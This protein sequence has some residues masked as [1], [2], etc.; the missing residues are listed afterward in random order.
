MVKNVLRRMRFEYVLIMSSVIPL[1]PAMAEREKGAFELLRLLMVANN[2][3]GTSNNNSRTF[4][5]FCDDVKRAYLNKDVDAMGK[6]PGNLNDIYGK[7]TSAR[8]GGRDETSRIIEIVN[9]EKLVWWKDADGGFSTTWREGSVQATFLDI[10]LNNTPHNPPEINMYS[11]K[12]LARYLKENSCPQPSVQMEETII[13]TYLWAK[14]MTFVTY[15]WYTPT[16]VVNG[17]DPFVMGRRDPSRYHIVIMGYVPLFEKMHEPPFSMFG[18]NDGMFD[19]DYFGNVKVS[20]EVLCEHVESDS[21]VIFGL[22]SHRSF[23]TVED[24]IV[25]LMAKGSKPNYRFIDS[26]DTNTDI[27]FDNMNQFLIRVSTTIDSSHDS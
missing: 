13:N 4:R 26:A 20:K 3:K 7:I 17:F 12:T 24:V 1:E 16:I 23:K 21:I 27:T 18:L 8:A 11:R 22:L 25:D 14:M 2:R 5:N 9:P 10:V 15:N 6:L 19:L